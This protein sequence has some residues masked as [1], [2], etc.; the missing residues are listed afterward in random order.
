MMNQLLIPS[1]CFVRQFAARFFIAKSFSWLAIG[2]GCGQISAS[3]ILIIATQRR[4]L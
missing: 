2:G 3:D 4:R 1:H